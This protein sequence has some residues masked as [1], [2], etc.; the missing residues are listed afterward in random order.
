MTEITFREP[1]TRFSRSEPD[2]AADSLVWNQLIIG[3][4]LVQAEEDGFL[5]IL[6]SNPGRLSEQRWSALAPREL[7]E[8]GFGGRR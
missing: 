5:A 4:S 6:I 3:W 1:T 7:L 8:C 2:L